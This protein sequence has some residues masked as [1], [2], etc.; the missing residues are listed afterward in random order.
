MQRSVGGRPWRSAYYMPAA[1]DKA[2]ALLRRWM[3]SEA[4]GGP[5]YGPDADPLAAQPRLGRRQVLDRLG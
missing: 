1:C 2:V 5:A 3:D 4:G